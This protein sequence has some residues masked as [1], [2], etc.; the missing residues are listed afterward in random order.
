MLTALI[1]CIRS[2]DKQKASNQSS[3]NSTSD[4][5]M[6]NM[7][8]I[9]ERYTGFHCVQYVIV[10]CCL[11]GIETESSISAS[12]SIQNISDYDSG[13]LFLIFRY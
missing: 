13:I 10:L 5:F 8:G 1:N 3:H 9:K 6:F 2:P 4:I 12:N 7:E 11:D